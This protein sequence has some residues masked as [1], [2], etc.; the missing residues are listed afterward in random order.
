MRFQNVCVEAIASYLPEEVVTSEVIEER[1]SAVYERLKLPKGRLELMS[2]ISER[3]FFSSDCSSSHVAAEAGERTLNLSGI[4]PSKVQC[5]IH[6]SVCKD[7]L[8]PATATVVHSKLGLPDSALIFDI[9]NA[10]LGVLNGMMIVA[11]MIEL[12]QIEAGLIV[13]GENGRSL[14]ESTIKEII[15]NE[16]ITRKSIKKYFASLTIGSAA[17][18]VLLTHRSI[19]KTGHRLLG[20][21]F[22]SATEHNALCT[23]DN[24]AMTTMMNTDSEELLKRGVELAAI[25]WKRVKKELGWMNTTVQRFICH[26]VGSAHK[27]LLFQSLNIDETKDFSTYAFLGNTGSAALPVTWAIAEE[28]GFL[29]SGDIIALLGIGSGIN[30]LMLGVEW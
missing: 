2:G 19:S 18:A 26:Q 9:S 21:S 6:A 4:D 12:G 29:E 8:E 16:K 3:R 28:K 7:F 17:A 20:G 14:V 5:L 30:S 13:S 10:C 24:S 27:K 25:T 15:G 11:N 1:L 23:G 22:Y